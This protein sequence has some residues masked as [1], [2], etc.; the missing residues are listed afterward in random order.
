M[1]ASEE[2]ALAAAQALY[3]EYQDAANAL[4]QSGWVDP[5]PLE[6]FVRGDALRDEEKTAADFSAK[7]YRQ[8][9]EATFDSM[10]LQQLSDT[11]AGSM[12]LTVYLC[13]DVSQTDIVDQGGNSISPSDRPL[14]L[15]LEVDFDDFDDVLKLS[16]S[17]LWSGENFC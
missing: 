8:V 5:S 17:E 3:G 4:G 7:G 14:R 11:G 13:L 9:G 1:F 16:R 12:V 10:A 6:Q 15:P 2:E